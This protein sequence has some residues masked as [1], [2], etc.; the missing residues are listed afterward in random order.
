[1]TLTR[2]NLTTLLS[3]STALI[4]STAIHA[5][6]TSRHLQIPAD[7]LSTALNRLAEASDLQMVYD[8]DMTQGLKSTALSGNYTPTQALQKLLQGSGLGYQLAANGTV[9]ISRQAQKEQLESPNTPSETAMLPTVRVKSQA[10]YATDDPYNTDY[11]SFSMSTA[12]KTD[13]PIC[14]YLAATSNK[15]RQNNPAS[16]PAR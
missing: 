16:T 3:V 5:E 11:H 10:E 8:T 15:N 7:Q 1:M 12:T 13:T 9:T 2:K 4:L 14:L 6:S